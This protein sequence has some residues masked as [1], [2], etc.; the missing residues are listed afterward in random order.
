[1]W[2]LTP[3]RGNSREPSAINNPMWKQHVSQ[4]GTG[5]VCLLQIAPPP[6]ERELASGICETLSGVGGSPAACLPSPFGSLGSDVLQ[7]GRI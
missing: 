4:V 3:L 7:G 6:G 2:I 1:M 5:S